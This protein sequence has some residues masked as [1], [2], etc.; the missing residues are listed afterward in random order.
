LAGG[1]FALLERLVDGAGGLGDRVVGA[2]DTDGMTDDGARGADALAS[3]NNDAV[4]CAGSTSATGEVAGTAAEVDAKAGA[5]VLGRR[6]TNQIKPTHAI[7]HSPTPTQS[8]RRDLVASGRG[9]LL[10]EATIVTELFS[11]GRETSGSL[12][13]RSESTGCT[14]EAPSFSISTGTWS[15]IV[16][17]GCALSEIEISDVTSVSNASGGTETCETFST[18]A[19]MSARFSNASA[20]SF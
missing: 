12:G 9:A 5:G 4:G 6:A 20:A 19:T 13:S 1:G 10:I 8:R 15:P 14:S 18:S 11:A 7:A 3:W 17:S 16:G 2:T